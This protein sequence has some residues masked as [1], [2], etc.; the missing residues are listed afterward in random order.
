MYTNQS[1]VYSKTKQRKIFKFYP[2]EHQN[3]HIEADDLAVAEYLLCMLKDLTSTYSTK[4]KIRIK[5][6]KTNFIFI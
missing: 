6:L 4:I 3:A 1:F 2:K 5:V